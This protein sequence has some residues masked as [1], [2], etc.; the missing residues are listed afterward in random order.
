MESRRK[1][2]LFLPSRHIDGL[3]LFG[4]RVGG[5]VHTHT[6]TPFSRNPTKKKK[7]NKNIEAFLFF[8]FFALERRWQT[9]NSVCFLEDRNCRDCVCL[10]LCVCICVWKIQL[11]DNIESSKRRNWGKV[12]RCF[13]VVSIYLLLCCVDFW[14]RLI[15][16]FQHL[17]LPPTT[18]TPSPSSPS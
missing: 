13:L 17:S 4:K 5:S 12:E 18:T 3:F 9:D 11:G 14:K 15:D 8:F 2:F 16:D 1:C 7:R 6:P 10:Y